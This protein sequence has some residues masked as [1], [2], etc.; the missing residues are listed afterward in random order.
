MVALVGDLGAGKTFFMQ[1]F[2]EKLGYQDVHSPTFSLMNEF[3][4]GKHDLIHMDL[5]RVKAEAE[6]LELGWDDLLEREGVF[7]A[8]WA[9]LFPELFPSETIWLEIQHVSE[10]ERLVLSSVPLTLPLS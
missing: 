10:E 1:H 9:N 5:Y 3:T 4:G 2:A 7:V 8:E 6:L